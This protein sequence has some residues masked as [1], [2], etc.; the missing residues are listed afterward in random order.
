MDGQ[1]VCLTDGLIIHI[2]DDELIAE[3]TWIVYIHRWTYCSYIRINEL[4][5]YVVYINRW[6]DCM[7]ISEDRL[8]IRNILMVYIHRHAHDSVYIY[9]WAHG[10]KYMSWIYLCMGL[11]YVLYIFT[12]GLIAHVYL[13]MG[14]G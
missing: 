3:N 8:I 7:Y 4:M 12:D 11:W 13:R 6:A 1:M 5:E 2:S 14:S 9:G 10:Q